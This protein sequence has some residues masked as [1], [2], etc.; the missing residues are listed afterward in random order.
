MQEKGSTILPDGLT[1]VLLRDVAGFGGWLGGLTLPKRLWAFE[2]SWNGG[3]LLLMHLMPNSDIAATSSE[4]YNSVME[5]RH[6]P[7]LPRAE[8]KLRSGNFKRRLRARSTLRAA[9]SWA[10]T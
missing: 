5:V 9:A 10:R 6:H 8:R 4:A 1:M 3:V 7:E 2:Q